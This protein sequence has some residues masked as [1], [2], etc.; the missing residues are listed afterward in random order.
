M[1]AQGTGKYSGGT[2]TLNNATLLH[3]ARDRFVRACRGGEIEVLDCIYD[4]DPRILACRAAF[5]CT[6]VHVAAE[7]GKVAV[8]DWLRERGADFNTITRPRKQTP[9]HLAAANGLLSTVEWLVQHAQAQGCDIDAEDYRRRTAAQLAEL[10]EHRLC[11]EHLNAANRIPMASFLKAGGGSALEN[12]N[13]GWDALSREQLIQ[14]LS[15]LKALHEDE[16]QQRKSV[17]E[18]QFWEISML[19]SE[20]VDIK[21]ELSELGSLVRHLLSSGGGE[22]ESA[23]E[24]RLAESARAQYLRDRETVSGVRVEAAQIAEA[25]R[26]SEGKGDDGD[27]QQELELGG[28][29]EAIT[30]GE[31]GGAP[32]DDQKTVSDRGP[33]AQEG[34]APGDPSNASNVERAQPQTASLNKK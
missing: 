26:Y 23:F 15:D 5:G 8:L 30:L 10:Y 2:A 14:G 16:L 9:L 32:A 20:M 11:A 4:N 28:Q 13:S 3:G 21:K 24:S 12:R 17:E 31:E 1:D 29:I 18:K 7:H 22:V 19:K 25:S 34:V 6:P 27:A 33:A